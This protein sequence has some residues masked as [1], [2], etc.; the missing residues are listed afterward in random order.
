MAALLTLW[1]HSASAETAATAPAPAKSTASD[2]KSV[3]VT[4]Y[5]SDLGLVKDKR[6]VSLPVGQGEL[7]FMDVASSIMPVTVHAKSLNKPKDFG[8]LEQNYEFDLMNA[9]KVLDKY[10]GKQIKIVEWN[11]EHDRK[12]ETEATL[13]SNAGQIYRIDNEIW[14][15]HDGI[16]VV[17][18]IP[19]NLIAKPTLTWLYDNKSA[20]AHELEVSYLASGMNWAADY[21]IVLDAADASV[22]L[23]GWVT[24]TNQSGASYK[25][26]R[27]KLV[28]G[29][30]NRV[31][32]PRGA[33]MMFEAM[34]M[35]SSMADAQFQEQSFFEYHI[36]DMKRPTTLKDNQS[37]QISLFEAVGVAARKEF[38]VEGNAAFLTQKY[39]EQSN[40]TP[41]N[42]FVIFKNAAANKLGMPLPAGVMRLYKQD[43][44][45]SLQ[46]VGEDRIEHTPKDEDVRL[47][48]GE[49]FD[50]AVERVQ[51]D[52]KQV[53]SNQHETEWEITLRNHKET[54]VTV[55]VDEPMVGT[56]KII[57]NS[58]PFKKQ[59]AFTA[60][61]EVPV[62]KDG[63]VK[64][65]YRVRV[66]I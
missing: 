61:F 54:P 38:I 62:P 8:I 39:W 55:V 14:L 5:N 50:I 42:V 28:A 17:P 29:E 52:Y 32:Q 25:N 18:E 46:F 49:A 41:V 33:P 34:A 47:R 35:K 1:A 20:E 3:E 22:D 63:E 11:K 16:K 7:R 10:E 26:A 65:K 9:S 66:G 24:L 31:Q 60:R 45:G 2:Q 57:S 48:I 6:R 40:K 37:K 30:V 19:E 23:S 59:D 56:W 4:V 27:L 12:E 51:T 36:Y 58:H 64:V 53:T 44:A 21:V 43:S 15:G 13:L